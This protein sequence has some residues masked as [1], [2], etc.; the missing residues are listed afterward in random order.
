MTQISVSLY[1]VAVCDMLV[2]S[3]YGHLGIPAKPGKE[4]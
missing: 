3:I 4:I 2:Q 1:A